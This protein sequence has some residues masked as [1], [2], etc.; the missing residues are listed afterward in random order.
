[1]SM[2]L[3]CP[4]TLFLPLQLRLASSR[5]TRRAWYQR[6]NTS[7]CHAWFTPSLFFLIFDDIIDSFDF[8]HHPPRLH[9]WAE[10]H[11]SA[12]TF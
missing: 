1:L 12:S 6:L 8:P 7:Q 5:G 4:K 2:M 11:I 9:K 3:A 10:H